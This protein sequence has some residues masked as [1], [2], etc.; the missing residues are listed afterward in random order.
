MADNI[1][2]E[3][4]ENISEEEAYSDLRFYTIK[5]GDNLMAIACRFGT[6]VKNLSALNKIKNP[7]FI[8]VGQ[9]L[10]IR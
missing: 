2:V 7:D 5:S 6:T 1:F 8:R 9:T 4:S 3:F 10:K